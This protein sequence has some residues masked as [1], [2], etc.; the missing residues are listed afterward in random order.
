MLVGKEKLP[1]EKRYRTKKKLLE[2]GEEEGV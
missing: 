2:N 1:A